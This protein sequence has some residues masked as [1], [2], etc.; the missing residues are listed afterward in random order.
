MNLTQGNNK[1]QNKQNQAISK[2]QTISKTVLKQA[3]KKR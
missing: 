3:N 1:M 2:N